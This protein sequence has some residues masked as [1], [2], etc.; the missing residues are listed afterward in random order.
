[1]KPTDLLPILSDLHLDSE[2][3]IKSL[4]FSN[5]EWEY[6]DMK[7]G[8]GYIFKSVYRRCTSQFSK[9]E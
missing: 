7:V 1:M 6:Y 9:T 8:S 2:Y 3:R 4:T 5:T